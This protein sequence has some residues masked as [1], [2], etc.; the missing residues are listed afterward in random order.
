MKMGE[1]MQENIKKILIY[2]KQHTLLTKLIVISFVVSIFILL[3]W[4]SFNYFINTPYE[5]NAKTERFT[6]LSGEGIKVISTNL[7]KKGLISNN[8][9]FMIYLEGSGLSGTIKAGDYELS[10]SMDPLEI[11]DILT[12]GKVSSVTITIPEGWTIDQIGTYLE[13]KK[14]VKK[15]DFI[16]ATKKNYSYDF[17]SDKP[18]NLSLEGFLFPDTYKISVTATSESII[19][20][21]L[22]NFDKKVTTDMRLVAKQSHLGLYKTIILASMVEK[23]ANK[24]EDRKVVAGVFISRLNDGMKLQSDVTVEYALGKKN[25]LTAEDLAYQSPYNTYIIDGLPIGPICN[26]GLE[27]INAAIY[28]TLT[29]FRYFIAANNQVYYAKTL[30]E[31]NAN[32]AKYLK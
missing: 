25:K 29:D 16:A 1:K 5:K 3:I 28:P 4:G 32:V 13:N 21:M 12:M 26:P 17:L 15:S 20:M 6:V 19:K 10:A 27:S 8:L 22:N 31:H 9:L 7:E 30:D 18:A 24:S 23:E 2:F 14:I 11:A